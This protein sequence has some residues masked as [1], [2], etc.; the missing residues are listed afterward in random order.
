MQKMEPSIL[1]DVLRVIIDDDDN[2][3]VCRYLINV[4]EWYEL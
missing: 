2:F 4:V 1:N 3:N